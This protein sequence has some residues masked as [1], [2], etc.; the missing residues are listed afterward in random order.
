MNM[1]SSNTT[2]YAPVHEADDDENYDHTLY[3]V[4]KNDSSTRCQNFCFGIAFASLIYLPALSYLYGF[5]NARCLPRHQD[6]SIAYVPKQPLITTTQH[7]IPLIHTTSPTQGLIS[8][9]SLSNEETLKPTS[10]MTW[11]RIDPDTG[12]MT[13]PRIDPVAPISDL[14]ITTDPLSIRKAAPLDGV[15]DSKCL[16]PA[17]LPEEVD[18]LKRYSNGVG[19]YLEWGIG[20]SSAIFA[21]NAKVAYAVDSMAEWCNNVIQDPCVRRSPS[22]TLY[23][24]IHP[25]TV[26]Q[27]W[28][29]PQSE[30]T[31]TNK[32]EFL[33]QYAHHYIVTSIER[34]GIQDHSLDFVLVD[35]R[36][37][38]ACA[39]YALRL[40]KPGGVVAIHD[41]DIV[42][43]TEQHFKDVELVYE[44][45]DSAKE[46][47]IFR[48]RQV[49]LANSTELFRKFLSD[50]RRE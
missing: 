8:K 39:V 19:S 4:Y 44:K 6:N 29:Y 34:L 38:V 9:E 23:C 24:V 41:Y 36:F 25:K 27:Y 22:F 45:I 30:D 40:L 13:W 20:G 46:A 35:G 14:V 21:P 15:G 33:R 10:D 42:R 17:M 5:N 3:H 32:N 28:G 7:T 12:D 18:I 49:A 50:P 47:A 2:E 43:Q 37:R 48:P 31:S 16:E 11:P 1:P 26:I